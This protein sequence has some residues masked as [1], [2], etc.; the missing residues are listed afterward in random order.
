MCRPAK[1]IEAEPGGYYELL[2]HNENNICTLELI[3]AG[4]NE[5]KERSEMKKL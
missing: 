1:R 2:F 4:E 3:S 5:L